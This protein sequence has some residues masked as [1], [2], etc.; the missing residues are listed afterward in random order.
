ME[1]DTLYLEAH[2]II[3]IIAKI[4]SHALEQRLSASDANV[5]G[6]Q[7]AI[8]QALSVEEHT[9]SE[10]S[11]SF[12]LDPSTLVPAVDALERKGLAKRGS[13]PRDRRRVPLSLTDYGAAVVESVHMIDKDDPLVVG[14]SMLNADQRRE[15]V[16]L[17]REVVAK[18]PQGEEILDKVLSRIQVHGRPKPR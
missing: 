12:M 14:L 13:D 9:I 18:M 16:E 2:I 4:S 1:S 11:Q 3:T 7:F 10:L 6:L 8:M 17:L 5:S 15:F